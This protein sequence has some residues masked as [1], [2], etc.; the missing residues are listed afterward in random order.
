MR[1]TIRIEAGAVAAQVAN[2]LTA[3]PELVEDGQLL[4]DMIEAE[5]DLDTVASR[6][7]DEELESIC[8]SNAARSRR[9]DLSERIARFDRRIDAMRSLL[10]SLMRTAGI[11]KLV[12]PEATVSITKARESVVI[13]DPDAVPSQLCKLIR[14]PDKDAIGKALKAG[15]LIPGAALVAG[16]AGL[17]IRTK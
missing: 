10:K 6:I 9:A 11:D 13:T 16:E 4:L 12:L 15:E 7:L 8:I 3:Y 1:D 14:Q 2:L 17:T 5:T